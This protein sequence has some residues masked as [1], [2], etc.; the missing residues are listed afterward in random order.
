MIGIR[1]L[2][3]FTG[4]GIAPKPRLRSQGF[5]PCLRG[6]E[7]K[8]AHPLVCLYHI[9]ERRAKFGVSA[10]TA[11][12]YN[13][14]CWLLPPHQSHWTIGAPLAAEIPLTSRHLPLCLATRRQ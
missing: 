13:L 7:E 11:P 1:V 2:A 8:E 5:E 4:S 6:I 10:A 9:G 14:H 12:G 3:P